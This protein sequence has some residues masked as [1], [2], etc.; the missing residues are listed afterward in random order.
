MQEARRPAQPWD[1]GWIVRWTLCGA[2]IG[3]THAGGG[4][5][6]CAARTPVVNSR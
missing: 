1:E 3:A 6:W 5:T 2:G 4:W